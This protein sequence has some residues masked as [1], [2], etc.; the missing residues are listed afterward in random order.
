MSKERVVARFLD[1]RLLKGYVIDFSPHDKRVMIEDLSSNRHSVDLEELK[2][3]FFVRTFEGDRSH[4]ETKSFMGT[5]P[6]GRRV[7]V[8][9]KDG[10]AM[11]GYVEGEVPWQRGFFLESSKGPGF[12]LIPVDCHSNNIKVFVVASAVGDVTVMG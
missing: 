8:R 5:V 3:I 11:T 6:S 2:A 4:I 1:G 12:F 7:F 9:F 10:E